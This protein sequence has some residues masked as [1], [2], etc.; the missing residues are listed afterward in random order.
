MLAEVF[1]ISNPSCWLA[2]VPSEPTCMVSPALKFNG[3]SIVTVPSLL[4]GTQEEIG[5]RFLA[6]FT[7]TSRTDQSPASATLYGVLTLDLL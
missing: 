6:D 3:R 4:T 2:S 7:S 5:W 1:D